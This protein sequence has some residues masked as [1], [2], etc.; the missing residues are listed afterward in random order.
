MIEPNYL[1]VPFIEMRADGDINIPFK[2][3]KKD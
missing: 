2:I 1:W 3:L